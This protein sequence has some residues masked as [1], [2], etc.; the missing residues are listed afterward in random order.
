MKRKMIVC[1]V[2]LLALDLVTKYLTSAHLA[3]GQRIAVIPDFFAIT[4]VRN[5]GAA[6]SILEGNR[7]FFVVI[8][9]AVS[10]YLMV[11]IRREK[12]GILLIGMVLMLTGTIGNLYDRAMLGYVRDMFAF[13]IFGYPFPVFNV[14]DSCLVIGVGFIFLDIMITGKKESIGG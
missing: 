9:I 2:G 6:W 5:T 14:A 1:G 13:N 8:A 7:W 12:K 3:L 4:Y 10:V 11:L